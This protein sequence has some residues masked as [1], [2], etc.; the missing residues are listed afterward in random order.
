MSGRLPFKTMSSL[1]AMA[2]ECERMSENIEERFA[3]LTERLQGVICGDQTS[4]WIT[5]G[6]ASDMGRL[7][8]RVGTDA[9]TVVKLKWS[10]ERC[11]LRSYLILPSAQ[12]R[13]RRRAGTYGRSRALGCSILTVGRLS[14]T[15]KLIFYLS[16]RDTERDLFTIDDLKTVHYAIGYSLE[17][18]RSGP[19]QPQPQLLRR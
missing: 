19:T 17:C 15:G 14:A 11:A 4:T 12:I 1:I 16:I 2:I 5:S 6:S 8:R 18:D 3:L 13:L 9:A 10:N 7:C